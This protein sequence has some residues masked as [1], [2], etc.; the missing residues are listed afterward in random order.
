LI[1]STSRPN[2]SFSF[3]K[4]LESRLHSLCFM[5]PPLVRIFGKLRR[6][7]GIDY[8]DKLVSLAE[9]VARDVNG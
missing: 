5:S 2:V 3:S 9:H 4:S 1:K 8:A 6:C 7:L